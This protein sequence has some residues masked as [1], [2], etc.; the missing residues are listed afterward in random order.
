M[1][2]EPIKALDISLQLALMAFEVMENLQP[3]V[4]KSLDIDFYPS[5][6]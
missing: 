3:A 4:D 1:L 6:L 5:V 2:L